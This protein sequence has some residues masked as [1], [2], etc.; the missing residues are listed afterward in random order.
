MVE[1]SSLLA[2][3]RCSSGPTPK[4]AS[5]AK[6][7]PSRRE[8]EG[9]DCITAKGEENTSFLLLA[10]YTDGRKSI[11]G[12][13]G[14]IQNQM[15]LDVLYVGRPVHLL[16]QGPYHDKILSCVSPIIM[17][18]YKPVSRFRMSGPVCPVL[19][20]PYHLRVRLIDGR[21]KHA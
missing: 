14:V 1:R 8:R 5:T 4:A 20:D 13:G 21:R 12:M 17:F 11:D 2:S 19:A 10:G 7:P 3:S 15:Q 6:P 18:S 9:R 16:L